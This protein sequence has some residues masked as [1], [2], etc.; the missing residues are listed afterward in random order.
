ME[1]KILHSSFFPEFVFMHRGA[2]VRSVGALT[3]VHEA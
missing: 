2:A 3:R 1:E